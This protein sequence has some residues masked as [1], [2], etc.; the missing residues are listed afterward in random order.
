MIF[1]GPIA[2]DISSAL[3]YPYLFI[4]PVRMLSGLVPI[5][6]DIGQP[7][8]YILFFLLVRKED[9]IFSELP[10]KPSQFQCWI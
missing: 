2:S 5:D 6:I 1:V 10:L 3:L 9:G 8:G 7:S 4:Q